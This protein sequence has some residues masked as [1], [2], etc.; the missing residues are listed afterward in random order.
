MSA[1]PAD[2]AGHDGVEADGGEILGVDAD[3]ELAGDGLEATVGMAVEVDRAFADQVPGAESVVAEDEEAGFVRCRIAGRGGAPGVIEAGDAEFVIMRNAGPAD[4][5]AGGFGVVVADDEV[6]FAIEAGE[7]GVD[8][9]GRA[10]TEIA[11]VPDGVIGA[12]GSVP[13]GDQG[14]VLLFHRGERAA[15]NGDAARF[16]EMGVGGE[17]EHGGRYFVSLSLFI[18]RRT[19]K[20]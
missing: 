11:Q 19:T 17:E 1:A 6:L 4:G 20:F 18:S 16:A 2:E 13:I 8:L 12:D 10:P 14:F 9:L 15:I 3:I 7:E 5:G